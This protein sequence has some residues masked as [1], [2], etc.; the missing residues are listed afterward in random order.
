MRLIKHGFT[1]V[2][3]YFSRFRLYCWQSTWY[4][5]S[6]FLS[7][8]FIR[9]KTCKNAPKTVNIRASNSQSCVANKSILHPHFDYLA[10]QN[11]QND[12]PEDCRRHRKPHFPHLKTWFSDIRESAGKCQPHHLHDRIFAC[13]MNIPILY[14]KFIF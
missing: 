5:K 6:D 12:K 13:S 4:T 7:V 11:T 2:F 10:L 1:A 14:V 9:Q 8:C 3:P